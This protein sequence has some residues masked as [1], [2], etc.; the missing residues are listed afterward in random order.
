MG[1]LQ[2]CAMCGEHFN[3]ALAC[4][5]FIPFGSEANVTRM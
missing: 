4:E 3:K 1:D 2:L 5:N